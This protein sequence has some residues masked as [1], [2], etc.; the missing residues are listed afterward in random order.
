[1][2]VQFPIQKI[3]LQLNLPPLD[4][5]MRIQLFLLL[6]TLLCYLQRN[7]LP[8]LL[9]YLRFL[10]QHLDLAVKLSQNLLIL[11]LIRFNPLQHQAVLILHSL[12]LFIG[13]LF[14]LQPDLAS[15][16]VPLHHTPRILCTQCGLTVSAAMWVH[17]LTVRANRILVLHLQ[18]H[19][20]S[21]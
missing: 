13:L 5:L 21:L 1:M 8:L 2:L 7:K 11:Q 18:S 17:Q 9:D 12:G 16:F 6:N 19:P 15:L 14:V 10:P 20:G 3:R 4:L